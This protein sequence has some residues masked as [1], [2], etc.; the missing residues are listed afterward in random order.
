MKNV[1]SSRRRRAWARAKA[2]G[3]IDSLLVSKSEDVRYLSGFTGEDSVLAIAAV[4]GAT[5]ITDGRFAEQ[6]GGEC[7][8]VEIV[9]RTSGP[10][11]A[12][13]GEWAAGKRVRRLG[14]QGGHLTLLAGEALKDTKPLQAIVPLADVM[15]PLREVKDAGEIEAIR[16]SAVV[17]QKAFS[18]LFARGKAFW[19]GRTERQI[20]A[21]LD[22]L[23]G[24]HGAE[25]PSFETIVAVGPHGSLPHHRPGPRRVRAGN[26]I[27]VDWGAKVGG[28]CSDLTRV[29]F[30]GTIPPKLAGIY[31]VVLAAQAAGIKACRAGA[32][33]STVDAA[34][35]NLIEAAGY[36]KQFVHGLGHGVGLEIHE[37]PGLGKTSKT[38]LRSGMVVT[39]EPGIYV[40]G[41]G[42]VRIEDDVLVTAAGWQ[43]I[44]TLPKRMKDM[45]L[46]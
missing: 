4:G 45:V 24:L 1:L 29:V 36:G 18:E 34:A 14:V 2:G 20:A 22:Y 38:R 21:E 5:L 10:I 27:L 25:G 7:P 42:G 15:G 32:A 26:S 31:E 33:C 13:V 6:A 16:K 11:W 44:T 3:K 35:R 9:V 12:A 28:Y 43:M 46:R 19:V 23:M 8:G 30:A 39:V 37:A 17:A 41:V 40:P